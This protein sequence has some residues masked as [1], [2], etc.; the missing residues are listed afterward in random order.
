MRKKRVSRYE[1]RLLDHDR[2]LA[3]NIITMT[4]NCIGEMLDAWAEFHGSRGS[5][6]EAESFRHAANFAKTEGLDL[7]AKLSEWGQ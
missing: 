4:T 2:K 3:C 1:R 7:A 5:A 6:V